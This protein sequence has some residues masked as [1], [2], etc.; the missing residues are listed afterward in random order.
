M[1][2]KVWSGS[3]KRLIPVVVGGAEPP[4]F[5]RNW[6]WLMVDPAVEPAN[7]TRHVVDALRSAPADTAHAPSPEDRRERQQRLDEIRRTAEEFG[8]SEP[9]HGGLLPGSNF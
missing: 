6:E 3:D 1:L 8:K 5:L 2:T 4:P 9:E 7:W